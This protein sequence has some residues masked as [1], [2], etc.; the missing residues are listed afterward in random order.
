MLKS[1]N[2]PRISQL[3]IWHSQYTSRNDCDLEN[4]L[5]VFIILCFQC[6]SQFAAHP[7]CHFRFLH[8]QANSV[9]TYPMPDASVYFKF[10]SC[11]LFKVFVGLSHHLL[12]LGI[13]LKHF[14]FLKWSLMN[15][16]AISISLSFHCSC[17]CFLVL[18]GN[19]NL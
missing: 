18:L 9:H 2:E 19:F 4:I 15:V 16:L 1:V 8:Q 13:L 6:T 5:L 14:F 7:S 11:F 12:N 10:S 3:F 17:F